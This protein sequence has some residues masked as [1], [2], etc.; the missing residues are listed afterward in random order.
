MSAG[1]ETAATRLALLVMRSPLRLWRA[2]PARLRDWCIHQHMLR[3]ASYR[4]YVAAHGR[5]R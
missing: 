1:Y 5:P 2:Y 4:E 3:F